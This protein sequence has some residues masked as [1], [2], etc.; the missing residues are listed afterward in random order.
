MR[1]NL[2]SGHKLLSSTDRQLD[3]SHINAIKTYD[4][5]LP[6]TSREHKQ[7]QGSSTTRKDIDMRQVS[8]LVDMT[9][10]GLL[11]E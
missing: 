2:N 8:W 10:A 5:L 1:L 4:C 6:L 7:T 11:E 3:I 9:M